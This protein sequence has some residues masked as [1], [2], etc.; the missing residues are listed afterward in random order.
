M[1]TF[2]DGFDEQRKDELPRHWTNE[3]IVAGIFCVN[4]NDV[5][6]GR[7]SL[8]LSNSLVSN[9]WAFHTCIRPVSDGRIF[10]AYIF[11]VT[12]LGTSEYYVECARWPATNPEGNGV[13]RVRFRG[14]DKRILVWNDGVGWV[15]LMAW[16]PATWTKVTIRHNFESQ[17]Y[18]VWINDVLIAEDYAFDLPASSIIGFGVGVANGNMSIDTVQIGDLPAPNQEGDYRVRFDA[19]TFASNAGGIDQLQD[20]NVLHQLNQIAEAW[21]EVEDELA[22]LMSEGMVLAI[23]VVPWDSSTLE[24]IFY[25][26]IYDRIV[27]GPDHQRVSARDALSCLEHVDLDTVYASGIRANTEY[28]I[29]DGA[30]GLDPVYVSLPDAYADI[31]R[32]ITRVQVAELLDAVERPTD[33]EISALMPTYTIISRANG[34]RWVATPFFAEHPRWYLVGFEGDEP[35]PQTWTIMIVG[36]K[37]DGSPDLGDIHYSSAGNASVSGYHLV[38]FPTD[39]PFRFNVG[40]KYYIVIGPDDPLV[41]YEYRFYSYDVRP[42]GTPKVRTNAGVWT[43]DSGGGTWTEVVPDEIGRIIYQYLAW[44]DTVEGEDW[45]LVDSGG[46]KILFDGPNTRRPGW[47]YVPAG[48]F[49]QKGA[50]VFYTYGSLDIYWI[51]ADI[52][53]DVANV[54]WDV[55]LG[56]QTVEFLDAMESRALDWLQ[57]VLDAYGW[58][59]RQRHR[60]E[61][62]G[63]LDSP[64]TVRVEPINYS[65]PP[66]LDLKHGDD[67]TDIYQEARVS[68][69]DLKRQASRTFTGSRITARGSNGDLLYY[70]KFNPALAVSLNALNKRVLPEPYPYLRKHRLTRVQNVTNIDDLDEIADAIEFREGTLQWAG[71]LTVDGATWLV[72]GDRITYESSRRNLPLTEFLVTGVE[73]LPHMMVLHVTSLQGDLARIFQ[74]IDRDLGRYQ[75]VTTLQFSD[76]QHTFYAYGEQ[77]T[78]LSPVTATSHRARLY[79]GAT[80]VSTWR[81]CQTVVGPVINGQTSRIVYCYFPPEDGTGGQGA[82]TSV[83]VK[84]NLDVAASI[85]VPLDTTVYHW[86]DNA[87]AVC[88]LIYA[89]P[90]P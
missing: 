54:D 83:S 10:Q 14:V 50:R 8:Q 49:F 52:L 18:S 86:A 73:Y 72:P 1:L 11:P 57:Q 45:R 70:V 47:V 81:P 79:A 76:L 66:V 63:S 2:T 89:P 3:N 80:P 7:L 55:P 67:S 60:I 39:E 56:L 59:M 40:R 28:N 53:N 32:P 12:A 17:T 5:H 25:G 77:E 13:S 4:D 87:V 20:Y 75:A 41:N 23:E 22:D 48:T 16:T 21:I 38:S 26:M 37:I 46:A 9:S 64:P 27:S 33:D 31:H 71:S 44:N 43:W 42:V 36:A 6:S 61:G 51:L 58:R 82:A 74:R 15:D 35:I 62:G 34:K 29:L 65:A 19:W 24:Q 69:D 88:V 78:G 30:T 68:A 85:S 84:E 90:P